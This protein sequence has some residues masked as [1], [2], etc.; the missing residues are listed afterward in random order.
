MVTLKRTCNVN[1][2]ENLLENLQFNTIDEAINYVENIY[3]DMKTIY[4]N[5]SRNKWHIIE[6]KHYLSFTVYNKNKEYT[7]SNVIA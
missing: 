7:V 2:I 5:V 1:G 6:N 3:N 4:K